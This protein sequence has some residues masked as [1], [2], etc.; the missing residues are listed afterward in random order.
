MNHLVRTAIPQ[1]L[2]ELDY[3]RSGA[4]AKRTITGS[5]NSEVTRDR[6]RPEPSLIGE[7]RALSAAAREHEAGVLMPLDEVQAAHPEQL[8]HLAMAIQ[9]LMRD[10][11]DV[12]FAAAGLTAGIE[13]LLEH[14]GTTFMRRANRLELGL[15]HGEEVARALTTTAQ[16]HGRPFAQ[17]AARR[18]AS[19]AQGYPYLVQLVGAL[20]WTRAAVEQSSE[21]TL[22]HVEVIAP[23]LPRHMGNQ[24]HKIA[25]KAVPH[26][27]WGFLREMARLRGEHGENIPTGEIARAMGKS[28]SGISVWRR[29]L[30]ERDLI[31]LGSYGHVR[32]ALPYLGEYLDSVL[33]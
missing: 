10:E 2:A 19:L 11:Y 27:E 30:I 13:S 22:S 23:D 29:N 7:L 1:A 33:E 9:D 21:I 20:S 8:A 31:V 18:A 12:A 17:E 24:V 16:E 6:L 14:P 5:I 26:G 3:R 15:L 28:P 4:E 32:F 25:L